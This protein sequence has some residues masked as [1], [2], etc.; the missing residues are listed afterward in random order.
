MAGF[1]QGVGVGIEQP[2][3]PGPDSP[4][5]KFGHLQRHNGG[6]GPALIPANPRLDDPQLDLD[7]PGKVAD[8]RVLD[9]R[10]CPVRPAEGALAVGHQRQ[11]AG[12][13]GQ[14]PGGAQFGQR[15]GPPSGLVGGHTA[16]LPDNPDPGRELARRQRV[17]VGLSRFFGQP[18]GYQPP[19]HGIGQVARQGA[20]FRPDAGVQLVCANAVRDWETRRRFPPGLVRPGPAGGR[21]RLLGRPPR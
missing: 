13:P 14:P 12:T 17:L 3:R 11:V 21:P 10:Q 8:R 20:Q 2:G 15:L 9:D 4:V 5:S 16:G 18:G 7:F 6:R 19:G 1:Q